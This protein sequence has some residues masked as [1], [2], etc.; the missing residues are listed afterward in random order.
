MTGGDSMD[1]ISL[2]DWELLPDLGSSFFLEECAAGGGGKDQDQLLFGSGLVV[3]DMG[4]FT[5]HPAS[6]PSTYDC[7]LDE[8]DAMGPSAQAASAR[9][10]HDVE[11]EDIGVV[12]AEPRQGELAMMVTEVTISGAEEEEEMVNSPVAE[13]E[14]GEED[15]VMVEAAPDHLPHEVEEGA[16]RDRAGMDAAG[17]SVGKLRVNGVGALCSFGVAA[18][19]FCILVLGGRPQQQ[20]KVQDH[21][22]QFQVFADDERIHRAVE[23]ASRLNQAVSS[24]MGGAS[25]RGA[26]VS[27]GGHYTGF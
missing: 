21:K 22:S 3:I 1:A 16:E 13:E 5:L 12:Q 4:H 27:F 24:V 19:T 8:E 14:A 10:Q 18:A 20:R 7:I 15:E 23:Q 9:Q 25:T 17:F 2:D 11:F 26:T 6:H